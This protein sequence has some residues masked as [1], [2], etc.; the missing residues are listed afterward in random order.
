[1]FFS[2]YWPY[3]VTGI[4]LYISFRLTHIFGSRKLAGLLSRRN[5][6]ENGSENKDDIIEAADTGKIIFAL[7]V[8]MVC[9]FLFKISCPRYVSF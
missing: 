6:S 7:S 5:E 9:G 3:F 8:K 2:E 4:V 1:M